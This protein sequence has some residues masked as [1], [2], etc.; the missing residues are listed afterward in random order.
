ML[1]DIFFK[2]QSVNHE[3]TKSYDKWHFWMA[4]EFEKKKKKV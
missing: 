1:S 3:S 2:T 4:L